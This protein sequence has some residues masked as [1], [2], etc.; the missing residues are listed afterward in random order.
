MIF[1]LAYFE[2]IFMTFLSIIIYGSALLP[3]WR[4]SLGH[5]LTYTQIR[6]DII[7]RVLK[8]YLNGFIYKAYF[9]LIRFSCSVL[10]QFWQQLHFFRPF[11]SAKKQIYKSS[12]LKAL[13]QDVALLEWRL[14]PVWKLTVCFKK[15]SLYAYS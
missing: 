13:M 3:N 10:N 8:S 1:F 11:A 7:Y 4:V 12:W 5:L 9:V 6:L 15:C 2:I 14:L